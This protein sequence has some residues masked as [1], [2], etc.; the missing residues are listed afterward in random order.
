MNRHPYIISVSVATLL[1]IVVWLCVPK[2]YTA[3]TKLSDEYKETEL[4]IGFN[5]IRAYIKDAMNGA[6]TGMNDMEIYCKVLKTEDFARTISHK[7][8]PGKG[9]T[10]GE[11]L[12]EEDTIE[13]VLDNINYNYSNKQTTLAISFTDKD[14][15]IA[16]QMLDSVTVLLQQIITDYRQKIAQAALLNAETSLSAAKEKY[17]DAQAKYD[18]FADS[19][20][21]LSSPIAKQEEQALANESKTAYELYRKAAEEYARQQALKQ[22]AYLSFAVIQN[23]SVPL[24]PAKSLAGYLLSFIILAIFLTYGI[25]HYRNSEQNDYYFR[26]L[27]NYFSP[28]YLTIGIWILILGLYYILKT[29]LYPIEGQFYYCLIIWVPVFC[30]CALF[31]YM[32]VPVKGQEDGQN[33]SCIINLHLFNFLFIISLIITPLY[34]YKIMHIILM[35]TSEDLMSNIRTLAVYGEGVGFLGYSNVINQSLFVVA[36]WSYPKVPIWKIAILTFACILNSLAIMEKGTIFFVFVCIIFVLF[37]KKIIRV[38]SI[39]LSGLI[40]I[41]LFYFFNL[42]RAGEDSDYQKNETLLDFFAM[43]ALSPP[44]AFCQ[45]LPEVTPQFGTNTFE[46]IYLF[47]RRFGEDVVV[48]DKLQEFVFVPISTNVYTL[49]QPF[50]I[51]FGYK[52]IAFFATIYGILAGWLYK[53]FAANTN[54]GRCMYTYI[55][56]CLILQFYQENIF[57]SMV[58]VLQYTFFVYILTKKFSF[59]AR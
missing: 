15:V 54:F 35:F 26:Q 8:I 24:K 44:V 11:Y 31:I 1:A 42:A 7:Q 40:L 53:L 12:N 56:Y 28:W 59:S 22:R 10:Y 16:A 45:L 29:D 51:D 57:L 47:L 41:G 33:N 58:F 4:A 5:S 39:V 30:I 48:K 50:F 6:N 17:K 46:T 23:N 37:E 3:I 43:Y 25:I 38:R 34:I 32:I 20:E 55:V 2:E 19:H 52:G 27:G 49:F 36:I 21:N 13:A 14:P 9:I 18:T